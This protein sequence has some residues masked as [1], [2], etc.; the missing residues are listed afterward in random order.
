LNNKIYVVGGWSGTYL[1]IHEQ[2][3]ALI[4]QLI[5]LTGAG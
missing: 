5:P 1:D 3:L 2:Y 4:L